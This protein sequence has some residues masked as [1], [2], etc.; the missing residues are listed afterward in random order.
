MQ[1]TDVRFIY[2][3]QN[4]KTHNMNTKILSI[5]VCEETKQ[6]QTLA[7]QN[8]FEDGSYFI[9]T[10]EVSKFNLKDQEKYMKVIER[11]T[12]IPTAAPKMIRYSN[13]N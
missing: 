9:S 4:I 11:F 8:T 2:C 12:E 10:L 5:Y 1:V 6:I 7:L 13:L 3:G